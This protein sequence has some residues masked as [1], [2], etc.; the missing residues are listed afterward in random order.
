MVF[1]NAFQNMEDALVAF[2]RTGKLNF[3]NFADSLINDILRIQ[4]RMYITG[5]LAQMGSDVLLERGLEHRQR[6]ASPTAA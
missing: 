1:G 4:T 5:P 6:S 2:A 3:R